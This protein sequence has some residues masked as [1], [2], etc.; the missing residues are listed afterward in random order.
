MLK[1]II[2][3]IKG[4]AVSLQ[5]WTGPEGSRNLRLLDFMTVSTLRW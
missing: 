5:G 3:N 2:L 4:K 1:Y